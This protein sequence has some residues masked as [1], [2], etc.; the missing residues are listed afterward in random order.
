MNYPILASAMRFDSFIQCA[1]GLDHPQ[2]SV[3]ALPQDQNERQ[4][5]H[6]PRATDQL[7]L[8]TTAAN[9]GVVRD[10]EG[11]VAVTGGVVVGVVLA[12]VVATHTTP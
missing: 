4:H 3:V 12:V 6:M 7:T 10:V 2:L 5:R 11:A 9:A 8:P 1:G